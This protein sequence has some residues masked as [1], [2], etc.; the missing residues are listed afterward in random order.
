MQR[1]YGRHR[2]GKG[3]SF[4]PGLYG[5]YKNYRDYSS[6]GYHKPSY[7]GGSYD[8]FTSAAKAAAGYAAGRGLYDVLSNTSIGQG[9]IP[10]FITSVGDAAGG[11]LSKHPYVLP[12]LAAGYAAKEYGIPA[13]RAANEAGHSFS[14][15]VM[16]AAN[17]VGQAL[18]SAN[19]YNPWQG[20]FSLYGIS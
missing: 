18:E 16:S 20:M 12:T 2:G 5:I 1:T 14:K 4:K 19:T 17:S 6:G 9:A 15:S 13:L 3:F 8:P 11:F 10:Q 7:S